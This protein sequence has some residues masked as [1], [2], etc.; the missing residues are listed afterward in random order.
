MAWVK[1]EKYTDEYLLKCFKETYDF[2]GRNP[3]Y[4]EYDIYYSNKKDFPNRTTL[5]NRLGNFKEISKKLGLDFKVNRYCGYNESFLISEIQRFNNE[6]GRPPTTKDLDKRDTGFPSRKT[7]EDHFG[8]FGIALVKAGF[9]YR[10]NRNSQRKKPLPKGVYEFTKEQIKYCIDEYINMFGKIP[11]LKEIIKIPNYPDRVDFRR[12]F[13]GFN[14]ALIEFGYIPKHIQNYSDEYLRKRF[15]DFVRE[16]GRIPSIKEFNNSTYPSFWSYQKRFGS[17]VNAVKAYGYNPI[18][19]KEIEE[20]QSDIIKLCNQIYQNEN[21]KTITYSDITNSE[22]CSSTSTY[23]KHFKKLGTTLR[24]F[25]RSIGF[26]FL[27]SSTGMVY[28]FDDGEITVSKMEFHTSTYLR[29]KN[30]KY[31]RNI[32]YQKFIKNYV[33]KKDCDYVI[34]LNNTIWYVEVAGMYDENNSSDIS[35]EYAKRLD[36]KIKMLELNN[37]NYKIIYPLDFKQKSLDEI[38]SFLFK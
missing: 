18:G 21:R 4:V 16:N 24:E 31:E 8:T 20:L 29:N 33:G 32:R 2:Y 22:F 37:I 10:G 14:N 12:L 13:G 38:F 34:N 6:N 15:N 25:V 27:Y 36:E 5:I 1:K 17:W 3:S 9:E 23:V 7:Y 26:D 35:I 19:R 28:E 30:V 11:S